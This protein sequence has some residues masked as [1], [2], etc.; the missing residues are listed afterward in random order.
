M[1]SKVL[2]NLNF[3]CNLYLFQNCVVSNVKKILHPIYQD[4]QA[5]GHKKV[6]IL[7]HQIVQM[8]KLFKNTCSCISLQSLRLRISS[9]KDSHSSIVPLVRGN[10]LPLLRLDGIGAIQPLDLYSSSSSLD[11]WDHRAED[12]SNPTMNMSIFPDGFIPIPE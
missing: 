3:Y 6:R 12:P 5:F 4:D 7:S 9:L 2:I 8:H 1:S 11:D 10:L